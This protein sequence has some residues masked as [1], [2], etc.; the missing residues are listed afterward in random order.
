MTAVAILTNLLPPGVFKG[1]HPV[2]HIFNSS[3]PDTVSAQQQTTH[4]LYM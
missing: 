3:L 4:S 2:C 1:G